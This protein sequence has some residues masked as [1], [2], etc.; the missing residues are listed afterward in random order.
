MVVKEA[1][2]TLED[3]IKA[4]EVDEEEIPEITLM[5]VV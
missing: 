5:A 3:K 1:V 4:S 2:P